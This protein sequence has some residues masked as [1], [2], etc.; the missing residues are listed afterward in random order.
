MFCFFFTQA[1][2]L[3]RQTIGFKHSTF[4]LVT[5]THS[6]SLAHECIV[7]CLC[8]HGTEAV[9]HCPSCHL[10]HKGCTHHMVRPCQINLFFM[11]PPTLFSWR[12]K[13]KIKIVFIHER[14]KPGGEAITTWPWSKM[15][16]SFVFITTVCSWREHLS[17]CSS[18]KV[19][20]LSQAAN[21][22]S[23]F[24][25]GSSCFMPCVILCQFQNRLH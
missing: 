17:T 8:L 21:F 10:K 20:G 2:L 22:P 7:Y 25:T 23:S 15:S 5:C 11:D 9:N 18:P 1:V 13:K 16:A 12:T 4:Y 14:N 24:R 3:I 6:L 19:P